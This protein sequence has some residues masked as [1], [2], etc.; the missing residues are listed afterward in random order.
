[1]NENLGQKGRRAVKKEKSKRKQ[2][3]EKRTIG[4]QGSDK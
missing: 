1:M 4:Q 3:T 2:G